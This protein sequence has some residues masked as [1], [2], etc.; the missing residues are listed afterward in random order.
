M[1]KPESYIRV[2][3]ND[4]K[5]LFNKKI[6]ARPEGKTI[7]NSPIA[8]LLPT[9]FH[10]NVMTECFVAFFII[11]VLRKFNNIQGSMKSLGMEKFRFNS[12]SYQRFIILPAYRFSGFVH[13]GLLR[14]FPI[15]C[16]QRL[17]IKKKANNNP[18]GEWG[19]YV[20]KQT[21]T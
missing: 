21:V 14:I 9:P 13:I 12:F 16:F 19:D 1:A 18:V 7:F 17:A 20:I 5:N 10:C 4:R 11:K 2:E 3:K 8:N 15:E 6:R